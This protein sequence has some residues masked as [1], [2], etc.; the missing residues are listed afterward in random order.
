MF[1]DV[2]VYLCQRKGI[3]P[4]KALTDCGVSRTS[5][6]KW[7]KGAVP[8]GETLQKL[9]D[10]FGVST[11]Y[12]LTGEETKNPALS[13]EDGMDDLLERLRNRPECR[14]LFKVADGA[15]TADVEK[16]V[17]IIEAL[18]KTGGR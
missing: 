18:R 3:T 15:T 17:A 8:R 7:R 6:A 1:Y 14:I 2:F 10:Y 4:N 11:D 9:S 16:A 13:E 12:L 5:S